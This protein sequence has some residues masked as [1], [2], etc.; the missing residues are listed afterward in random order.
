[1][2]KICILDIWVTE[3]LNCYNLHTLQYVIL[4]F[5]ESFLNLDID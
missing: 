1:M 4:N 2:E 5:L 3:Y